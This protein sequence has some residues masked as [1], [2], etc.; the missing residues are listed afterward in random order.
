VRCGSAGE[1]HE[2]RVDRVVQ[3]RLHL[4]GQDCRGPGRASTTSGPVEIRQ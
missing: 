1:R 3:I 2:G 4:A